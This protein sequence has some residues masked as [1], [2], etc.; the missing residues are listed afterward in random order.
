M[1]VKDKQIQELSDVHL[2]LLISAIIPSFTQETLETT[3][4]NTLVQILIDHKKYLNEIV[5]KL[6]IYK[7]APRA[8]IG[9]LMSDINSQ[10]QLSEILDSFK[11]AN[12]IYNSGE[13]IKQMLKTYKSLKHD[14]SKNLK[15]GK[16]VSESVQKIKEY[17]SKLAS[18]YSRKHIDT[19]YL[20][21]RLKKT[22][23]AHDI[24]TKQKS[25]L[26]SIER[27]YVSNITM[28]E[29]KI[30]ELNSQIKQ[31]TETNKIDSQTDLETMHKK[32]EH[33][34]LK[35]QKKY[36]K[37]V[38]DIKSHREQLAELKT[39]I[40]AKDAQI[41]DIEYELSH[42]DRSI[43]TYLNDLQELQ[44]YISDIESRNNTLEIDNHKLQKLNTRLSIK[45]TE[46][47]NMTSAINQIQ[48]EL[49][50]KTVQFSTMQQK[51]QD[52]YNKHSVSSKDSERQIN[53][54]TEN[55]EKLKKSIIELEVSRELLQTQLDETIE[56]RDDCNQ[57][58][59]DMLTEN[60]SLKS[61][62]DMLLETNEQQEGVI[63]RLTKQLESC[64]LTNLKYVRWLEENKID[65]ETGKGPLSF[66]KY[67]SS[68]K[69]M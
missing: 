46:C 9:G 5:Q 65:S 21:K 26:K 64:K 41:K 19:N 42:R 33:H 35:L 32:L 47:K 8:Q 23:G 6:I 25:D 34:H 38:N 11:S 7:K 58:I 66:L 27:D 62:T 2:K 39:L 12:D 18:A 68:S 20:A 69:D 17:K 30:N 24:A 1:A 54:L 48:S 60:T 37:L 3:D 10:E 61:T 43:N 53:V 45:D 51:L 29:E 40:L 52:A 15:S 16:P 31:L 49:D 22:L 55:V 50:K 63:E 13:H 56:K 59:Q 57:R 44:K 28:L 14:Y 36:D 4:H 67:F